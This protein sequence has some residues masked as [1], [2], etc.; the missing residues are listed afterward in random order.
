MKE[1][2]LSTWPRREHFQVFRQADL[3]FYNINVNLDIT[4]VRAE[5]R[6]CGVP[7]TQAM[8][9]LVLRTVNGIENFRYRLHGDTVVLHDVLH[10]S[11]A[12]IKEG[13]E[14]FRMIA[15]AFDEDLGRFSKACELA[16]AASTS[17]FDPSLAGRDDF[18][19]VSPLPW[20]SFTGTD[21]TLS[22]RRED[23]IPRITWGRF[24]EAGGRT[25]LPF[26]IQ[27]NHMFVDGLH[28]GRFFQHLDAEIARF[29]A[30]GR[31]A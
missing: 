20:I 2:D 12:H 11:F 21:H 19:F 27:V 16:I 13:E 28:V 7:F 14:L 30:G 5:A 31:D 6:N 24:F 25:L 4:G 18:V 10:P 3:P 29:C 8:I 15:V 26:N 23:G 1:I 9:H 22:L 17:Y